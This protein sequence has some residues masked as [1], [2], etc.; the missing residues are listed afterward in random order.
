MCKTFRCTQSHAYR[1]SGWLS[2]FSMVLPKW[3]PPCNPFA[4]CPLLVHLSLSNK[5][6][7]LLP[8]WY[9]YVI[10]VL[11]QTLKGLEYQLKISYL[12]SYCV[13]LGKPYNIEVRLQNILTLNQVLIVK[14]ASRKTETFCHQNLRSL[15]DIWC[16]VTN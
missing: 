15:C 9:R 13:L 6:E 2:L 4:I 5:W 3:F 14:S 11:F 10:Y 8:W 1:N 16:E 7:D 12:N